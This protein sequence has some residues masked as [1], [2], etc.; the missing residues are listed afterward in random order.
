MQRTLMTK[1]IPRNTT[2]GMNVE[3]QQS[4][5]ERLK[6]LERRRA[7]IKDRI[8]EGKNKQRKKIRK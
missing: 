1:D 7:E 2:K 4:W 3:R 5:R 8:K 6:V